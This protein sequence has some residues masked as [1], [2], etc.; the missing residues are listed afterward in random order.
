MRLALRPFRCKFDNC[1][2]TPSGSMECKNKSDF[3]YKIARPFI[4][5]NLCK[6]P[7]LAREI[8]RGRQLADGYHFVENP[9][10]ATSLC[11][12]KR[13]IFNLSKNFTKKKINKQRSFT[14]IDEQTFFTFPHISYWMIKFFGI[15]IA[16]FRINEYALELNLLNFNNNFFK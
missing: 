11:V 4:S 5:C 7:L 2:S 9:C 16:I 10:Y 15:E 14:K 1:V 8:V 13:F 3:L 12:Q 6:K